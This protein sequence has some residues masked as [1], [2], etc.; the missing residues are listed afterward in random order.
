[1]LQG[2]IYK[3][4]MMGAPISFSS[5]IYGD[6]MSVIHNT[7]LHESKLNNKRNYFCCHSVCK[8]VVMGKTL[9]V[10]KGTNQNCD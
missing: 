10:H 1:M 4:R 8:S 9:T 2:I 6:N 3:M 5:Y 7:Q